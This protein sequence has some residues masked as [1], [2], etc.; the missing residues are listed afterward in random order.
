MTPGTKNILQKI[1]NAMKNESVLKCPKNGSL[2]IHDKE[3]YKYFKAEDVVSA[4]QKAFTEEGIVFIIHLDKVEHTIYRKKMKDYEKDMHYFIL[5]GRAIF[6]NVDNPEDKIETSF[7]G[8]AED[9][10]D[11]AIGKANT[12]AKKIALMNILMIQDGEDTDA[13]P[14]EAGQLKKVQATQIAVE[15]KEEKILLK[16]I[17]DNEA[18]QQ[19]LLGG[20]DSTKMFY[21]KA[22]TPNGFYKMVDPT[23]EKA[24]RHKLV[25]LGFELEGDEYVLKNN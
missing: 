17:C 21:G 24:E 11:K 3:Q 6:L 5:E 2:K 12:Y 25:A 16:V 9:D 15:K 13:T 19:I 14:S 22:K 10:S 18:I 7:I 23:W 4:A 8:S 20:K 1:V